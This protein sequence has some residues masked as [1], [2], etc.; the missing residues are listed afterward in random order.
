MI[1]RK[2]ARNRSSRTYHPFFENYCIVEA[3]DIEK[4]KKFVQASIES[5]R[6]ILFR[7]Q[8]ADAIANNSITPV[9]YEKITGEAFDTQEDLNLWLKEIWYNVFDDMSIPGI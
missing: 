2:Y 3:P 8:L 5:E 4:L 7:N 1:W 6:T 9:Q